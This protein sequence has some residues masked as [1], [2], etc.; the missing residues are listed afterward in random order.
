MRNLVA[1]ILL[2]L[3][4]DALACGGNK[5]E[6]RTE[7]EMNGQIV[8]PR[9]VAIYGETVSTKTKVGDVETGVMVLAEEVWDENHQGDAVK[10]DI[11]ISQ[12]KGRLSLGAS[13]QQMIVRYGE[14][15]EIETRDDAPDAKP[16]RLKVTAKKI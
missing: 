14:T 11:K 5:Y 4:V 2:F 12:S 3:S 8:K 15:A 9:I 6:L 13:N 10:L 16:V 7:V 1:V